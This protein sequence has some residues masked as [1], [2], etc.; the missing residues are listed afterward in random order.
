MG[1]DAPKTMADR[2]SAYVLRGALAQT[3][4]K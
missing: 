2:I 1:L 4:K 3:F